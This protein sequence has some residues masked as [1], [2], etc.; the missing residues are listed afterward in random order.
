MVYMGVEV[1]VWNGIYGDGVKA[2]A[3]ACVPHLLTFPNGLSE[4]L[5][6]VVLDDS[7]AMNA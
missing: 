3:T 5:I 6:E 7:G 1:I 4:F 2:S